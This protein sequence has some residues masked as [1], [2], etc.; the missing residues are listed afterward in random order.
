MGNTPA[1]RQS[2][3]EGNAQTFKPM[4]DERRARGTVRPEEASMTKTEL[5]KR[6][7]EVALRRGE[8]KLRS[9]Q[10]SNVYFDKYQFEARPEL[11]REV[12]RQLAPLV[13]A[14]TEVLAGLELGGVPIATAL[15]FETGLPVAFVRKERKSYG[16]C[17]I[18]EGS[19]LRGKR[20]CIVEDVITTGG[21]VVDSANELRGEGALLDVVL[22]VIFRGEGGKDRLAEAGLRRVSLLTLEDLQP[23][24]G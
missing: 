14:G 22:S 11:L 15:A 12:A 10:T 7:V 16:T 17:L 4:L 3:C 18:A 9:G 20:V 6:V 13:P 8:F 19:E 23:F 5:A 21:A 2:E 1:Y 24:M